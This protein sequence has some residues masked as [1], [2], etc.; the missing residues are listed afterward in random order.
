M[1][2]IIDHELPRPA[3][4]AV[5][6]LEAV[7][8]KKGIST[9]RS[10]SG[11]LQPDITIGIAT[12]SVP[13]GRL[14]ANLNLACPDSPESLLIVQTDED[15]LV[16]GSDAVGLAYAVYE[17]ARRI[18][19]SSDNSLGA[20]PTIETPDLAWRSM[21]LFLCNKEL[22]REWF[23]SERFWG[24]YL[25]NLM[26]CRFNNLSLTY[27]HQ[28]PYLT[29]PY[30]FLFE[31]P[32]FPKVK[33]LRYKDAERKSH[34]AMLQSISQMVREFG[35]HFTLG[36]WSQHACD[37]GEPMLE[38]LTTDILA[39]FNTV[40]LRKLLD[41]CPD[42]DGVQFRMNYESGI[43]EDEQRE[44][45]EN[46][47]KVI[48]DCGRPIRL[49][50]RAKGLADETIALAREIV[51]ETVV[52]TKFWCEH[53]GLPYAM[54]A[55][56]QFDVPHYRRYGT[57]DLL[58]K[59]RPFPLVH[60]L[61]SAGTQRILLWGEPNWVRRFADACQNSEGFEVMAP[62]TNKGQ[63]SEEGG[64]R[65]IGDQSVQ[66]YE[67]EHDRYWMFYLLFGRLGYNSDCDREVWKRE[68]QHRLGD[69]TNW[70]LRLYETSGQILPFITTVFQW[71]ASLWGFWPETWAGRS[72]EEDATIEPSDPTQ[73]HRVDEYVQDA[74]NGK[75]CGKW[76]PFQSAAHLET[77]AQQT[78]QILSNRETAGTTNA[79]I[80]GMQMDAAI[81]AHL[82]RYHAKR[83][84]AITQY[85]FHQKTGEPYRL[86]EALNL[87]QSARAEWTSLANAA[88]PYHSNLIFGRDSFRHTGHW[89]DWFDVIDKDIE[90]LHGKTASLRDESDGTV[91]DP[92][93]DALQG[94][95]RPGISVDFEVPSSASSGQDLFIRIR[96]SSD[97]PVIASR[98]FYRITDQALDF[99]TIELSQNQHQWEGSIP[100]DAI[101]PDWDLMIFFEFEFRNG[102]AA[103]W[104]DWRQRTPYFVIET[105]NEDKSNSSDPFV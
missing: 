64:W 38:G 14:L 16:C 50:I 69:Q 40:G 74:L 99:R 8:R 22:E 55:I 35:L 94:T 67:S 68:L 87:M 51:P 34:L 30:P 66:P 62:L 89:K 57:W 9:E 70:A 3:A 44:F 17:A 52:S 105:C 47:F 49:D 39:E 86:T 78:E 93:T 48:A 96:V 58:K 7:L 59:P 95:Q 6:H 29:P 24:C 80:Q 13:V 28:T 103:R 79:E 91:M 54:P 11:A 98:C 73:F 101:L 31:M 82:A 37:Y 63:L 46:Q 56:Q 1:Q 84:R 25:K 15:T 43:P 12:E 88:A 27:G 90:H 61:W 36:I 97:E 75:L 77:L 53:L 102:S 76:T 10:Q 4:L 65:V 19:C 72:L 2:L 26:A 23:Y 18:E 85:A 33:I 41:A 104:P 92:E 20:A 32:E 83:L 21:Q 60:R 5:E 81:L 42:I 100:A 71:S 45:Y